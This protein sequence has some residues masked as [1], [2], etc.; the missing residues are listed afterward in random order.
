MTPMKLSL[1]IYRAL[2]KLYP[3]AFREEYDGALQRQFKDDYAEVRSTSDLVRFWARTLLDF[4]RSMPSQFAREIAQD[5]RHALRLWRRRPLTTGFAIAALAIA[6]GANTG[7]FS[8]LNAV[9]LRS[10]PFHEPDRARVAPRRFCAT[11]PRQLCRVS[12]R[13]LRN[14]YLADAASYSTSL[15]V[16][17]EGARATSRMRLTET[18]WNFFSLLGVSPVHGRSFLADEDV[19]GRDGVAVIG[20]GLWQELFGGDPR[21]VGATIHV[22][23]APLEV[24]GIAPP[25]FDYPQKTDVW[26]PTAFDFRRIP[27]TGAAYFWSTIGRLKPGLPWTQARRAFEVEAYRD[28]ADRRQADA[29]NRPALIPLQEQLAGPVRNASLILMA[30]VSLLLLLACANIANPLLART[31]AR[32][33]VRIRTAL[34]ASRARLAQQ[35]LTETLLLSLVG[36]AA[37]LL[38]ARW[39]ATVAAAVQ[40]AELSSQSYT[41]LDWRVLGFA[42]AASIVTGVIFGVGPALYATRRDVATRGR[43]ATAS[44]KHARMRNVLIGAQVAITIV[45]LTGSVALGS[46]FLALLR[47]DHGFDVHSIATMSVS[48]AGTGYEES[49]RAASYYSDVLD[50][51]RGVPG[52]VSASATEALPLNVDRFARYGFRLDTGE[53]IRRHADLGGAWIFQHNRRPRGVRARVLT[54]RPRRLRAAG[55]GQRRVRPKLWRSI[56]SGRQVAHGR[57][58]GHAEDHRCGAGHAGDGSGVQSTPPSLLAKP[59]PARHDD[60]RSSERACPGPDRRHS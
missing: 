38:V 4:A 34:G 41:I 21:A 58:H 17:L 20:Y 31:I 28:S 57:R 35:L 52:V 45:L 43:T 25:G 39:T 44:G 54:A 11:R 49:G 27:K 48:L 7:V 50:R 24:V 9:L 40:P 53:T 12:R 51:V 22:N 8:V 2:L 30:G 37:G 36:T 32:S 19:P 55:R 16:N 59:G 18:S 60:R 3:A 13:R 10:L 47:V 33:N 15:E 23:G 5:S 56:H 6:I 46:A 1:R 42:I 26:S 14:I 29:V